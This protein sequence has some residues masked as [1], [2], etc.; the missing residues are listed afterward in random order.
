MKPLSLLGAASTCWSV[1]PTPWKWKWYYF[2]GKKI[3]SDSVELFIGSIQWLFSR[4]KIHVRFGCGGIIM[5]STSNR[6]HYSISFR[7]QKIYMLCEWLK[8]ESLHHAL[9]LAHV[10]AVHIPEKHEG[11]ISGARFFLCPNCIAHHRTCTYKKTSL[12]VRYRS[13]MQKAILI[14][15]ERQL[16]IFGPHEDD[17]H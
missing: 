15:G 14:S 1:H 4:S 9:V 17:V 2:R 7:Y 13:L 5:L 8:T 11:R 6:G 16:N 3:Y 12:Q 10:N